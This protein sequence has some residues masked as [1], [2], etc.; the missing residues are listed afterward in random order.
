[1]SSSYWSGRSP[2]EIEAAAQAQFRRAKNQ[3]LSTR[4]AVRFGRK[5]A[6]TV[7]V[8]GSKAGAW[9]DHESGEGGY[10]ERPTKTSPSRYPKRSRTPKKPANGHVTGGSAD[11]DARHAEEQARQEERLHLRAQFEQ[12]VSVVGTPAADYLA[13]RRRLPP[14]WPD[15]LRYAE[16]F[17]SRPDATARSVLLAAVTD[18]KGELAALHAIEI[19]PAT[20]DKAK[21]DTPKKSHG[22]VSAGEVK[23]GHPDAPVLVI[24]E[25]L[26]TVLSRAVVG[27]ADLRACC[28]KLRLIAPAKHHRRVEILADQ[29]KITGARALAQQY[30][31]QDLEAYVVETP[32]ALGAKADLNDVLRLHGVEGVQAVVAK[33]PL[34]KAHARQHRQLELGS[35]FD[36]AVRVI[37]GMELLYGP[38]LYE[39]GAFWR[40]DGTRWE[41]LSEV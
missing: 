30:A 19:D 1:M 11:T 21:V 4:S 8:V 27:Q 3:G 17:R 15:S 9:Y 7:Q 29:D 28:G 5:G 35:D 39:E 16:R 22:P 10:L 20:R 34:Y 13:E 32:V 38:I 40:Y 33:A 12:A 41:K 6:L 36:I 23:L 26:E 37:E 25:G 14:P 18:D 24:G 31:R 2:A